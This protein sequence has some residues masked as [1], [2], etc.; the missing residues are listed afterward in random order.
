MRAPADQVSLPAAIITRKVAPALAAGR[1]C[2]IKPSSET[3][4]TSLTLAKLAVEAGIPA[5]CI[6]VCPT[7]DRAAAMEIVENPSVKLSFTRSTVMGKMLCQ[8][9]AKTL[10]KVSME[11]AGNAPFM[12]FDDAN[13]ELA[14]SGAMLCKFRCTDKLVSGKLL[15]GS[16]SQGG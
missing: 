6:Q 4:H 2:V 7:K 9:A 16:L 13:I 8:T 10:K 5:A 12:V 3:P 11:L 1:A 15:L 14:V